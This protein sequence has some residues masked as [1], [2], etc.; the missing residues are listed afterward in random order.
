MHVIDILELAEVDQ[1]QRNCCGI[2][3]FRP[4]SRSLSDRRFDRPINVSVRANRMI[5]DSKRG[6]LIA[7][8]SIAAKAKTDKTAALMMQ[9]RLASTRQ[10]LTASG[11]LVLLIRLESPSPHDHL[12]YQL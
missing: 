11:S 8:A 2:V 1:D 7:D 9:F 6:R 12:I 5:R 10:M 3:Q 4:A